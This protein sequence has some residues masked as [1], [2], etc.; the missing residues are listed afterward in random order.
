MIEYSYIISKTYTMR[1][2][3]IICTIWPPTCDYEKLLK[4]AKKG[5][6]IARLNM[7][8]GTHAWHRKVIKSVKTINENADYSIA[9]LLDTK[10]P[11]IRSW[12]LKQAIEIK[13]WDTF[14]FT[15][16]ELY[17]EKP[18]TVSVNYDAFI[19]DVDI[20]NIILVDGWIISMEVIE[21]T[22]T[23]IICKSLDDWALSSRRHLNIRWK[24]ADLPSI[25]EK[26]W[27]DI[28]FWIEERV[29]FLALSF[30]KDAAALHEVRKYLE[31]K[32]VPIDIIAKIETAD[33]VKCISEIV[34]ASDGI[35]VARW[36]LWSELPPEDVPII[37]REIIN[38]TKEQR[39]P[40]IIATHLLESMIQYPT[41]TRAEVTDISVAVESKADAIMLSWETAWWK[42]PF[43][44]LEMMDTVA[45]KIESNMYKYPKKSK[46][47]DQK[48]KLVESAVSLSDTL[49]ATAILVFTRRGYMASLVAQWRPHSPIYAFTNTSS[50]RRKLHL[51]WGINSFRIHF[52]SD[53]EKTIKR[54]VELLKENKYIKKQ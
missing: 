22:K 11:E 26:D 1:K 31:K 54:A 5:M 37:Q 49:Q 3:K 13:T 40:V 35:M 39:K 43:K 51:H 18:M 45:R 48:Y 7:S 24:S 12:D 17:Q 10:W 38:L 6:N 52:S 29:D 23:D 32:W 33:A 28:D 4:L 46:I 14:T 36:D 2:T 21:K 20:G 41:P 15:I 30:I 25:T 53:P 9:I 47:P 19:D 34:E 8:H 50:K 44:A 27:K 42:Y 16:K